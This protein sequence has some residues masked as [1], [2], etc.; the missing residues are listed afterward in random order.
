MS[1][2]ASCVIL[3]VAREGR[4]AGMPLY[5]MRMCMAAGKMRLYVEIEELRKI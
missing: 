5:G 3:A 4:M 1:L 2:Q